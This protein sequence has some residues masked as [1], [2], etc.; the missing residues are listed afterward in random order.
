MTDPIADL[1]TRIRN[2]VHVE[3]PYV[4]MPCSKAKIAIVQALAREGY[5]CVKVDVP[6]V[7]SVI[8]RSADKQ[9]VGQFAANVRAVRPPEPYKGKGIR[10]E[11]EQVRRK[12]GH[13]IASAST[14]EPT[15][16]GPGK[17]ASNVAAAT[18]VGELIAK[19]AAEKGI[20]QVVFDR[21]AFRYHGR[22]AALADAA[23]AQGLNF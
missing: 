1:L 23:R 13:T 3:R 11:N 18:A 22:I 15:I 7:T 21:G 20:E 9:A 14:M 12:A 10:Y 6:A 17:V 19:R 4:D 8:V 2:G 16:A 5:V